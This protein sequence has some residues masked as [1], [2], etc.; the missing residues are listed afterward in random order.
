MAGCGNET[1]DCWVASAST[2]TRFALRYGAH[3]MWCPLFRP[4]LDP[5]DRRADAGI[6]QRGEQGKIK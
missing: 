3:S 5:V 2:E 6:R 4:S 1:C